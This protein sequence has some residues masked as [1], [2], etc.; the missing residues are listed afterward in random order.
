MVAWARGHVVGLNGFFSVAEAMAAVR[1]LVQTVD[2]V[3]EKECHQRRLPTRIT[4]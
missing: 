3:L 2:D 4:T 1:I